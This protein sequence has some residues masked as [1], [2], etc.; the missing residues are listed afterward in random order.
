MAVWLLCSPLLAPG[1]ISLSSF[2]EGWSPGSPVGRQLVCTQQPFLF[3]PVAAVEA[4]IRFAGNPCE[5]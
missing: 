5:S 4:V 1:C 2:G 3:C